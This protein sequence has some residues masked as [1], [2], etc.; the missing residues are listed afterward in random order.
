MTKKQRANEIERIIQRAVANWQIPMMQ[1]P[2]VYKVG[3]DSAAQFVEL[4]AVAEA[5][6]TKAVSAKLVEVATYNR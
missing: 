5:E 3:Q 2:A 4:G 6:I 1:I